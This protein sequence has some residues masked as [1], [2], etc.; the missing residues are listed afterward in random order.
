VPHI[1]GGESGAM[2]CFGTHCGAT[3][4][5]GGLLKAKLVGSTLIYTPC[6]LLD[7]RVADMVCTTC[8]T[9]YRWDG[10]DWAILR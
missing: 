8:H 1:S 9:S 4:D 6:K 7:A 2:P 10:Y 5:C 3:C